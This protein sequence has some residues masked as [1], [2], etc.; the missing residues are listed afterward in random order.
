MTATVVEAPLPETAVGP[1]PAGAR[2]SARAPY[3]AATLFYVAFIVRASGAVDG[4]RTFTLFDDAMISMTY[5]RNLAHGHGLVWNAGGPRVE[6]ITNVLWTFV[7]VVPHLLGIPDNWAGLP[8]I[9]LGAALCLVCGALA[10][11]IVLRLAPDEPRAAVAAPWLVC[12]CYPLVFWALRGME[13][14]LMTALL[15]TAVLLALRLSDAPRSSDAVWL[16]ATFAAGCLTRLDFAIYAPVLVIFI[17]LRT[18]GAA[19]RRV[20]TIV[21]VGTLASLV[22]Q[23]IVRHAYYGRWVPNT[24]TLKVAHTPIGPRFERGLES[25]VF[26]F[27]VSFAAAA[28]FAGVAYWRRR[29]PAILLLIGCTAVSMLYNVYVGGDAW[30]WLRF[31]NRYLT[32]ALVLVLCLGVVGVYD[33]VASIKVGRLWYVVTGSLVAVATLIV[34]RILPGGERLFKIPH[35]PEQFGQRPAPLLLLAVVLLARPGAALV[36][37]PA[38][39]ARLLL[40]GLAVAVN[41]AAVGYWVGEGA[42]YVPDDLHTAR[43]GIEVASFTTPDARIAVV[44]AGNQVYFAHRTA[45]DLLGKSDPRIADGPMRP[46]VGFFPGHMK[47]NYD[48]S[49][50]E[51]RPD[52]VVDRWFSS[53]AERARIVGWGYVEATPKTAIADHEPGTW[54]YLVRA[55]SPRVHWD[56]LVS[57]TSSETADDLRAGC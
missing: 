28:V 55:G 46:E 7:M 24:Y 4:K 33:F 27:V 50:G 15:L 57:R 36:A 12:F 25:V 51:E 14:G 34:A 21:T 16:A 29:S 35:F 44:G 38:H 45:V 3:T 20:V 26:T 18:S 10:R 52:L 13:V 17:G 6:G 30:E 41:L 48:I 47:W 42:L 5:A 53:C 43:T 40:F 39:F 49:I 37:R 23:E 32:P 31:A 9:L 8:I 2:L 22:A 1:E 54:P 56:E 11:A 19:R